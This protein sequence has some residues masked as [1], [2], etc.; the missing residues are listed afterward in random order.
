VL[1]AAALARE[2][3]A[4]RRGKRAVSRAVR[5]VSAALG[6]TTTVARASYIDPRVIDA[7]EDGVVIELPPRA[8]GA[9]V[10]LRI[11]VADG[12]VVVE[13]PTHVDGDRLR[14]EVERR[15]RELLTAR[16]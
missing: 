9:A 13:L 8:S 15:V 3:A 6:N 1:A 11:D 12:G 2:H 10:P 4:G 16:P 5:E 14:L 7:Y